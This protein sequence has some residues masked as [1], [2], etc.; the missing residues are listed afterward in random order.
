MRSVRRGGGEGGDGGGPFQP[1]QK[2]TRQ[3]SLFM[4]VG[5]DEEDEEERAL[6]DSFIFCHQR[7]EEEYK[8]EIRTRSPPGVVC[9]GVPVVVVVV[10]VAFRTCF[11][12][13]ALSPIACGKAF[14]LLNISVW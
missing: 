8:E 9:W 11:G 14:V 4:D 13:D 1:S 3:L 5:K 10:V 12:F 2:F 6:F 7:E